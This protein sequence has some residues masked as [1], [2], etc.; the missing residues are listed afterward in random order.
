MQRAGQR[1]D[2]DSLQQQEGTQAA[3]SKQR[4]RSRAW[5]F[6]YKD[7]FLCENKLTETGTRKVMISWLEEDLLSAEVK[8]DKT[9]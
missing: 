3:H 6:V 7:R 1:S 5:M 2:G 8:K 9:N 4:L